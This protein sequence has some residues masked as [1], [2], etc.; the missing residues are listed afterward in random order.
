MQA[1]DNTIWYE[2]RELISMSDH[3]EFEA[4]DDDE[5]IRALICSQNHESHQILEST[6]TDHLLDRLQ[7]RKGNQVKRF[8]PVHTSE[9][10][11]MPIFGHRHIQVSLNNDNKD[12]M[13]S[14]E[15]LR[16]KPAE[17]ILTIQHRLAQFSARLNEAENKLRR[18]ST[19]ILRK[20]Q[21]SNDR[22]KKCSDVGHLPRG[23]P[24]SRPTKVL[25]PTGL[26]EE[27]L[28]LAWPIVLLFALNR[29]IGGQL[30]L[31]A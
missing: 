23:V 25:F 15:I 18:I 17:L 11:P 7:K 10:Y 31:N 24:S 19:A 22:F 21:E 2:S 27:I 4:T 26:C 16:N 12:Q 8:K 9:N 13:F 28:W 14:R 5:L 30:K 6:K 29:G 3:F 1:K 20:E